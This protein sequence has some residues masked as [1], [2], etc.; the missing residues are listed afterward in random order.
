M[1]IRRVDS[2]THVITT[3][4]GDGPVRPTERKFGCSPLTGDKSFTQVT[5]S[6]PQVVQNRKLR[7]RLLS[8]TTRKHNAAEAVRCNPNIT[9][10][11]QRYTACRPQLARTIRMDCPPYP[12]RIFLNHEIRPGAVAGPTLVCLYCTLP[13]GLALLR[14]HAQGRPSAMACQLQSVP[15]ERRTAMKVKTNVKAGGSGCRRL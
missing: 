15:G 4:A 10:L 8:P 7:E 6:A 1:R 11:K 3:V 9:N 2:V 14:S 5:V 12:K 13:Q